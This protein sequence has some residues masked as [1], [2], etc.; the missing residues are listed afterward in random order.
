LEVEEDDNFG[1]ADEDWDV[2]RGIQ[3]DGFTEDEEDD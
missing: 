1:A 3:K 2:Y